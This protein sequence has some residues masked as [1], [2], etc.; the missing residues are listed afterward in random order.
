[1]IVFMQLE[2]PSKT[3]EKARTEGATARL[4]RSVWKNPA[5]VAQLLLLAGGG[6]PAQVL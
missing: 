2:V 4:R 1:M 5:E 6:A 3:A